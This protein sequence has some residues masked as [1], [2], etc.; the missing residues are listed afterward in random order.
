MESPQLNSN[1]SYCYSQCGT[2]LLAFGTRLL[3]E[4]RSDAIIQKRG[5]LSNCTRT[6]TFIKRM[7]ITSADMHIIFLRKCNCKCVAS[8]KGGTMR[9]PIKPG[10]DNQPAGTYIEVG[11]LGGVVPDA[12]KV[13]IDFGDRL[14][15]TQ[16]PNR[17]W[18]KK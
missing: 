2:D 11:P 10:T 13:K 18:R 8:G 12:R 15:P 1:K 14:P 4:R 16:K 9:K 5:R 17:G 3:T 6:T 7:A